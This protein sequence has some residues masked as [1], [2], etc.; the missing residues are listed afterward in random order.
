VPQRDV[1]RL[2]PYASATKLATA[3][4]GT[5][6]ATDRTVTGALNPISR[7]PQRLRNSCCRPSWFFAAASSCCCCRTGR[8][9]M[10]VWKNVQVSQIDSNAQSR[11]GGRV[12]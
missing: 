2:P 4:T 9:S 10:L 12:Q 5:H 1:I 11:W 6:T 3:E 8:N 7:H